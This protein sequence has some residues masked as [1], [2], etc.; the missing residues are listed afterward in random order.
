MI[1]YDALIGRVIIREGGDQY[2]NY[3]S[4]EGGPTKFGITL[5]TLHDWRKAPVSAYDVQQLTL[6]EA[7]KI[8]RANYFPKWLEAIPDE[9]AVELFFDDCVN[10]GVGNLA[11]HAQSVLYHWHLYSGVIDGA[12]GPKSLDALG[13]V[14][15][16]PA[17]FYAVKCERLEMYLRQ[18]GSR[19]G[20]AVNAV[21]WANRNDQFEDPP[22]A[23]NGVTS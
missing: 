13:K 19:P 7:S 5:A 4:D 10:A 12:F 8:Y 21:G 18:I 9:S 23:P 15:N 17:F 6:S 14:K 1:D 20:N 11:K 2:T 16:W 3:P 22:G